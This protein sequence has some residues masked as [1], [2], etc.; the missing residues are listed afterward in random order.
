MERYTPHI[1]KFVWPIMARIVEE[2]GIICSRGNTRKHE[3]R[4]QC[5]QNTSGQTDR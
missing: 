3:S 5:T 2:A 4:L 1:Y